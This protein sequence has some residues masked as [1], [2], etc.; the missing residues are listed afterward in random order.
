M[1]S[2]RN[3]RSRAATS[4]NTQSKQSVS[5][6]KLALRSKTTSKPQ[7]VKK[8][9]KNQSGKTAGPSQCDDQDIDE[10]VHSNSEQNDDDD[11]PS[12]ITTQQKSNKRNQP[13]VSRFPG[14]D[15]HDFE[16]HLGDWT[17]ADL[18]DAIE[19]QGSRSTKAPSEIKATVKSIRLEYEKKMLMAALMGGVPEAVIWKLV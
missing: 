7:S 6:K 16:E 12:S 1:H 4:T 18:E 8:L 5:S 19:K 9:K 15:L 11:E 13:F 17:L 2:T 3:T 14:L 10:H